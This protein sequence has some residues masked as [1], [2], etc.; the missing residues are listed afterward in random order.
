M[1]DQGILFYS[2]L[3]SLAK[4]IV[5]ILILLFGVYT[6]AISF[7]IVLIIVLNIL[8]LAEPTTSNTLRNSMTLSQCVQSMIVVSI[9]NLA[10]CRKITKISLSSFNNRYYS[11][12]ERNIVPFNECIIHSIMHIFRS[13]FFHHFMYIC[14]L[15]RNQALFLHLSFSL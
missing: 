14:L 5:L 4:K 3:R 15:T 6:S 12:F 7:C 1:K 9:F 8:S 2:L 13:W 11:L 10:L